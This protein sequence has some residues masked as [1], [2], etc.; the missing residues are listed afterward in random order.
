MELGSKYCNI[1]KVERIV[2]TFP[3]LFRA[4]LI[5]QLWNT[6]SITGTHPLDTCQ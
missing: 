6:D 2:R 5:P 1:R 4:D 3:I